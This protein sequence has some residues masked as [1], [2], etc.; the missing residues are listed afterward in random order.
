MNKHTPGP[1]HVDGIHIGSDKY[2][3][4]Q[5]SAFEPREEHQANARLIAEAPA[6]YDVLK[7]LMQNHKLILMT[8]VGLSAEEVDKM[9]VQTEARE[10]ISRI[11]N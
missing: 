6:L 8:R 11:E 10:I 1:W 9:I 3:V 2:I 7:A 4:A 5:V